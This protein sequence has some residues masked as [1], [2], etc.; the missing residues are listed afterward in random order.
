MSSDRFN[1]SKLQESEFMRKLVKDTNP[2]IIGEPR[3]LTAPEID[4]RLGGLPKILELTYSYLSTGV[5]PR[6]PKDCDIP[7]LAIC[8]MARQSGFFDAYCRIRH[9]QLGAMKLGGL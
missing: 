1:E 2:T 5:D 4:K 8:A 9:T 6:L 3:E 7:L